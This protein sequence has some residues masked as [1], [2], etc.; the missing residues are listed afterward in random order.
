MALAVV[1]EKYGEIGFPGELELD[2]APTPGN[3]VVAWETWREQ[4]LDD[5]D[6]PNGYTVHPDGAVPAG[7]DTGRLSIRETQTGDDEFLRGL[8]PGSMVYAVEISGWDSYEFQG[9]YADQTSDPIGVDIPM[10]GAGWAFAGLLWRTP[11]DSASENIV[12][13]GDT[14]EL[15]DAKTGLGLAYHPLS[16]VAYIDADSDGT[17]QVT[18]DPNTAL[19]HWWA[20]H[21]LSIYIGGDLPEPPPVDPGYTPPDPGRAILEIYVHDEEATRWGTATWSADLTPTGT[22]GIWSGAGWQDVTPEGVTVH[23]SWGSSR[24]ERGILAIQEAQSWLVTTYDPDRVLDPGNVDGPFYPELVTGVPIRLRND[25]SGRTIRTGFI[26]R[27]EYAYKAPEYRGQIEASSSI[28]IAVRAKIEADTLLGNTLKERV[29]DAHT[30]SGLAIG[31]VSLVDN[32]EG[33]YPELAL[34]DKMEG[35]KSLWEHIYRAAQEIGWVAWEDSAGTF[36]FTPYLDP[37]ARGSVITYENLEDL[38]SSVSE[39]GQYSAVRVLDPDGTTVHDITNTPLPRY[40]RVVYNDREGIT[41]IDPEGFAAGVLADR[42]FPGVLWTPGVVWCF[43]AADVDMLSSLDIMERVSIVVPGVLEVSGP[44]LGMEVWVE[45]RSA[46]RARWLFLPRV[47]T[48]GSAAVGLSLL[49]ADDDGS[50][51]LADD[52]GSYME[53]DDA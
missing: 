30:A 12:P 47:A 25:A 23:I 44:L 21:T 43:T 27:I 37:S 29:L 3:L 18:G 9:S 2:D 31:G 53:P 39:D 6:G 5:G 34:S 35:E 50:F 20:A 19:T 16:W 36:R 7:S 24:P 14:V 26:D 28:A 8:V 33:V 41:T 49:L 1:Q 45:Q 52:D 11:T 15:N 32:G 46:E 4:D 42:A 22:E 40:G 13:T 10:D 51:L 38:K 17:W 48:T